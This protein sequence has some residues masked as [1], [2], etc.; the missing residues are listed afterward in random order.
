MVCI[1][2]VMMTVIVPYVSMVVKAYHL[3]VA[4]SHYR[5][6]F[7]TRWYFAVIAEDLP[8]TCCVVGHAADFISEQDVGVFLQ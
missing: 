8:G 2:Y 6:W 7:F 4:G 5:K 1:D 3:Y